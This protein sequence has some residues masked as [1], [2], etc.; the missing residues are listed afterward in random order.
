MKKFLLLNNFK[1]TVYSI[2]SSKM[3][4]LSLV[5]VLIWNKGW[6]QCTTSPCNFS[7]SGTSVSAQTWTV[8]TGVTSIVVEAWGGGGG[9]G[10]G[11]GSY[12]AGSGGSGSYVR[13]TIPVV[14]GQIVGIDVG[15][16]G[17]GRTSSGGQ[18]ETGGT[19]TVRYPNS[20][21]TWTLIAGG[22]TGGSVQ[23]AGPVAGSGSTTNTC[24]GNSSNCDQAVTGGN[25]SGGSGQ[26]PGA[27]GR[28]GSATTQGAAGGS[29]NSTTTNTGGAGG[30]AFAGSLAGGNGGNGSSTSSG[31]GGAGGDRAAGGGGGGRNGN[32]GKG[33]MGYVRITYTVCTAPSITSG[34]TASGSACVGGSLTVSVTATGT[35]PTCKWQRLLNGTYSDVTS[36]MDGGAYTNFN[37][38]TMTVNAVNTNINGRQF[39]CIVSNGCGTVESGLV[40]VTVNALATEGTFQYA[41][42]S[43]QNICA[44]TTISCTNTVSPT[45]GSGTLGVVWY[46]GE[47]TAGSPGAGGTYGN[48][49]GTIDP[50][51]NF[52]I[53]KSTNLITAIGGVEG[54]GFSL[55]NYNPQSDFPGKTN[56]RIIRRAYNSNCGVCVGGC[57]DQTF[58]LTVNSI[59]TTISGIAINTDDYVWI[60]NSNLDWLN[61]NNWYKRISQGYEVPTSIPSINSNVFIFPNNLEDCI[62]SNIPRVNS[63]VNCNVKNLYID[64]NAVLAFVDNTILNVSGNFTNFGSLVNDGGTNQLSGNRLIKL[65]GSSN[66]DINSGGTQ[67]T[68]S[69]VNRKQFLNLTIDKNGGVVKVINNNITITN[70]LEIISGNLNIQNYTLKTTKLLNSNGNITIETGGK[71]NIED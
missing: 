7:N 13:K 59:N 62:S 40:T 21:P 47:L 64:N 16:G 65:I 46:C 20:S 26:N 22:G 5:F 56:F 28:G 36:A 4:L 8:P 57:I 29:N 24:N 53:P 25:G 10:R 2:L 55:S 23:T 1:K 12:G 31:A 51:I 17:A 6:G 66:Q 14:A 15:H 45:A 42:G 9:G 68:T 58:Y 32:G 60:G 69:P 19:T 37:T 18:G 38:A 49:V 61:E 35:S 52:S 48:W 70:Q 54:S 30:T 34:P 67:N 33:G 44:G 27:G 11:N 41:N 43:T 50:A 39:R 63:N 3:L 71:L